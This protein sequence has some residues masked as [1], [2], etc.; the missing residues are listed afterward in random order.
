M[1]SFMWFILGAASGSALGYFYAKNR[2]EKKSQEEIDAFIMEER[3]RYSKDNEIIE[4]EPE[5]DLSPRAFNSPFEKAKEN[6]FSAMTDYS[7]YSEKKEEP[8]EEKSK[9]P[10]ESE[11]EEDENEDD[12]T[13]YPKEGDAKE[14]YGI[15][16]EEF[17]NENPFFDK[18]TLYYYQKD[19]VLTEDFGEVIQDPVS[20]LGYDFES[21]IGKHEKDVGYF[22]NEKI[23]ADYEV[24]LE[25]GNFYSASLEKGDTYSS[26]R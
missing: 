6:Y 18:E 25:K 13:L 2:L 26:G 24:I 7:S 19:D 3:E 1:R 12:G 20:L 9:E 21:E 10:E 4:E 22:R 11:D 17:A 5:E 14:P 23:G 8:K 15:T 16:P